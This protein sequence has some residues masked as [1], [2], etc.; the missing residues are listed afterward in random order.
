LR[1]GY[2]VKTVRCTCVQFRFNI[3]SSWVY[4]IAK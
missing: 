2:C 4:S 1:S 3:W